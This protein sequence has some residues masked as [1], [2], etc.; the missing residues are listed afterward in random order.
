MIPAMAFE[1][2]FT[3]HASF[4][5][6]FALTGLFFDFRDALHINLTLLCHF[7][8]LIGASCTYTY[9]FNFDDL[10]PNIPDPCPY[11]YRSETISNKLHWEDFPSQ[12]VQI[13]FSIHLLIWGHRNLTTSTHRSLSVTEYQLFM[14]RSRCSWLASIQS[15]SS[16]HIVARGLGPVSRQHSI[17]SN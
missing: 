16:A 3:G 7:L 2:Q 17:A 1:C 4:G 10:L 15:T 14:N 6:F 9:I 5:S 12:Y 13:L 11:F 8:C